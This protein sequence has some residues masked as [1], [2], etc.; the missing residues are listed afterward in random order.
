M[1]MEE[2][3]IGLIERSKC[4]MKEGDYEKDGLIYCGKCK[5]PKQ[6]WVELLGK[7]VLVGCL[8]KCEQ[9]KQD[10]E[11]KKWKEMQE[12]ERIKRLK[13][14]GVIDKSFSNFRFDTA[15]MTENLKKCKNY[16]DKWDEMKKGTGLLLWGGVGTG[17]TFAAACIVNEL[18]ER[19]IPAMITSF[20]RILNSGGYDK[21]EVA[22]QMRNYELV[23]IDDLG[24]ERDSEY[25]LETVYM[26]IDERYKSGKPTIVTT[27]LTLERLEHPE[28][29]RQKRI[30]D[31]IL[32]MCV[33]ICFS[34]KSRRSE[35]ARKKT[36]EAANLIL[37]DE[38]DGN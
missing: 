9:E 33:P 27:N 1:S 13:L 25:A 24:V 28:N 30:Y 3:I 19:G 20:P 7:Q 12:A 23:V 17:K 21:S 35:V 37:G 22:S 38:T 5:T 18:L 6:C 8:C 36:Q 16:A 32:E 29:I 4:V 2:A 31:R 26:V 34:G 11:A 10:S 15:E 14:D